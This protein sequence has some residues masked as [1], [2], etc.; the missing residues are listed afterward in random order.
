[1]KLNTIELSLLFYFKR[2]YGVIKFCLYLE[3]FTFN[4]LE[5]IYLRLYPQKHPYPT[6]V[7]G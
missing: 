4:Y 7:L 3:I 2:F 5:T 6:L 1:M